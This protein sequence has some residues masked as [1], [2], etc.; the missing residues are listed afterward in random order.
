MKRRF[1]YGFRVISLL[2][3]LLMVPILPF[4]VNAAQETADKTI[5]TVPTSID[6]S[7]SCDAYTCSYTDQWVPMFPTGKPDN[8]TWQAWDDGHYAN[9]AHAGH[10]DI[11]SLHLVSEPGKNTGVAINAGMTVG[12]EYVLGLWAKGSSNSGRVLALYANGD[13]LIIEKPSDLSSS[14]T[15][16]EITFT[17][18]VSQ[19]SIMAPDWGDTNILVD[20]ITLKKKNLSITGADLLSGKG[21][22]CQEI[23]LSATYVPTTI[24][25]NKASD[26]YACRYPDCW[27]P[28]FPTGEPTDDTWLAWDDTHYAEIVEEGFAD[29]G[30]LHMKSAPGK[31][32]AVAINPGMTAGEQY[33]LGMW[34]KGT[35]DSGRVLALY[36]NGDPVIIQNGSDLTADWSYYEITFTPFMSQLNLLCVDWGN[37]DLYID[38]ITLLDASG[39][40]LLA[41]YGDFCRE[42]STAVEDANLDFELAVG[43]MPRNWTHRGVL[44][45]STA[46]VYTENVYSGNQS[47][48]IHRQ[49][50]QLDCSFLFS[51]SLIPV[52]YGDEIEFVANIA[53]RNSV[54]GNFSMYIMGF[55][56]EG[57]MVDNAY[58]QERITNAGS[59]WS[60][61][62]TYS[63]L[64]TVPAGVKKIQLAL[65]VGGAEADVLVDD[66]TY[67]NY[68]E[69][70]NTIYKE[71][72]EAPSVTTG[73]PGG[74]EAAGNAEISCD[75]ALVLSGESGSVSKK[76]Y[77]LRTDYTYAL[78]ADVQTEGSAQLILEAVN[79][80]GEPAGQVLSQTISTGGTV[81][82]L[83]WHFQALSAV[84]YRLCVE[85]TDGSGSVRVDNLALQIK[86]IPSGSTALKENTISEP[87][88]ATTEPT[89][90]SSIETIGGRTYMIVNG[91]AVPPIWYARPENPALYEEHTVTKFAQVGVDTVVT[92]VFLNNNYG[93]VWTEEGFSTEAIDRMM[94]ATLQGNPNAKFIVALDFNAPQW[95]CEQN[96]GELA[97]LAS[98]TPSR[99]NASFASQKWKEE[100]GAIMVEAINYLMEQSYAN[101]IIGFKVTGGYTLEWN[102]WASSGVSNDVGDF[103]QCGIEGFRAWLTEKYRSDSALQAAYGDSSVTLK[104]AMPPS[105]VQ[106]SDDYLDTVITVQ[107]HPQMLD[108]ELYMAELKADTI[109]YFA[110]LVKDAVNDRLIVGTYGGYFYP[111]GGYEFSNAVS[112]VYFQKMLQSEHID[113]IKSPWMYGMRE[114]GDSA[115]FMGPVDSL[116]L[117]GKLWIVED[118]T[119]LNLQKM[120]GKQDDNASV[121]WTR[122]YQ[123][124]VEQLKRN[125]SYVLS[126]G[127]GISFYNLNWNFT[128][129][130]QYYGA[131]G[132]MYEEMV[133][134]LCVGSES[135]AEIAVFVDGESQMLVPYEEKL[136]NSILGTSLYRS[137]LTELGHTGATYDMYLLDDLKDGLVPEHKINVFLATTMITEEERAA[138]ESQ[139]QKNGNILVWI[140]TD[141]I[142]DGSTTDITLME[143]LTGMDLSLIST[144]RK[145]VA[146][147]SIT[148][149]AHWLTNG[150]KSGQHYGVETYDK[151][152][153][154]IA[155]KDS[156]ATVLAYHTASGEVGS[157]QA[158]LAVKDMGDWISVYSA[159]PNLPQS[160]F[161]NMLHK[162][163]GHIYTDSASDVI[164]ANSDYV[165]LHSLFAGERTIRLPEKATVYD[166]FSGETMANNADSFQ[167]TLTGKETRLFRLITE[168]PE[169]LTIDPSAMTGAYTAP[170][171]AWTPM[172]PAGSPDGGTWEAWNDDH[173]A[174][175]VEEGY[176]DPGA[177][178]MRSYYYKNAAVALQVGMTPG[179]TYTLGLWAKGTTD[180][181]RVLAL[182]ANGDPAIIPKYSDLTGDWSYY[183]IT[184]TASIGQIN[185]LSVDWG[186]TDLYVDNITLKDESGNDLLAGYGDFYRMAA[187]E[188]THNW[189][190]A[191]CTMPKTCAACGVTDGKATGHSYGAW[192]V[193]TP[194]TLKTAGIREKTCAGCGDVIT[195][196]I[197]CLAG[198]VEGW[199]LTLGDDLHLNFKMRIHSD[200]RETAQVVITVVDQV[201]S[202]KVSSGGYDALTDTYLFGVDVAAAQMTDPVTVQI[203]NGTDTSV[204]KT[205]TVQQYAQAILADDTMAAYHS[206]VK[207]M[208]RYGGAAQT[209]FAYHTEELADA[210]ITGGSTQTVPEKAQQDMK[211]SG[212][213]EGIQFYGASLVFE[214][215]I[216]VR[217]Y[218][219]V[220][221][222]VS[223]Y[224][225]GE[226][227][228]P[229][230]A[231][232]YYYVELPGMNPHQWDEMT[233]VSVA[234]G[235]GDTVTVCY[236]PMHYMV[237]MSKK[238][239][240]SL[241]LLMQAMYRYHLAAKALCHD[242]A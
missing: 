57:E 171:D 1:S 213:V 215:K 105:A 237:H 60:Q 94:Q 227:L 96:P 79:W 72:F 88:A 9:I 101:Q 10:S 206:L 32:A 217:Y 134:S 23:V 122:D 193:V 186:N 3:A 112:N 11:G 22:F 198:D 37:T 38:N 229:V 203:V 163:Q 144:A 97:A 65:R 178:H 34:V 19:L 98:T 27:A 121:G 64:Y 15:Y 135:T 150:I 53:S 165:A 188:S 230:K 189:V 199:S 20:N 202:H 162:V 41:G 239:S 43:D 231:G 228:T 48:R 17:A 81:Q 214:G 44:A 107:D 180:A 80:K 52:S 16:F 172:Y 6:T 73:L 61:W 147:A 114:I 152:S 221:G 92:Y 130:D 210:G 138:I 36:A 136:A 175:I 100:S 191:S 238:G 66:I 241:K 40:D 69:N 194:A 90:T 74:W 86:E 47:L 157:G 84:Y 123:Q 110:A 207:E 56:E 124:S 155:V 49:N 148:N 113:F 63:L 169:L 200:I 31:N 164:Y 149:T 160:L 58:G 131:I 156:A 12:S 204:T 168:Q 151:L 125:F 145:N 95:W 59:S 18:T 195:E 226:G 218:F 21:D 71:D 183:E 225:F 50:G 42:Y 219:A 212:S 29:V 93:D 104:N 14:W 118:D 78:S 126:K 106:R 176:L 139:L 129:D 115:E 190:A 159:V 142:S 240:E 146:T 7:L 45:D 89:T 205:Y 67:Y 33:T 30:A 242:L 55:D 91:E 177:L 99:T 133:Q 119:R 166:A 77:T 167:V 153:P 208:L 182:Y 173:Y 235:S 82:S 232:E 103:S 76:L 26:A 192:S 39:T 102:W 13:P 143:D 184:F 128:D 181:G 2:L 196:E 201:Y 111:G 46:S 68:I 141:G 170:S 83:Q 154:V 197:P 75:G 54:S 8:G 132:Q 85:K 108:Y 216:A 140:F 127:M 223:A 161:R 116:D 233:E 70:Y 5:K 109:E 137:Q 224:T 179:K 222:D 87:T 25:T 220:T 117:Y 187:G 211:V 35:S 185:L 174:E 236:S 51:Q 158:A 62:D 24:Y 234:D 28:M 209:F 4:G 120:P